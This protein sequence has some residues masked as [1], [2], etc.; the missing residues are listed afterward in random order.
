MS[1]KFT[2]IFLERLPAIAVGDPEDLVGSVLLQARQQWLLLTSP[3]LFHKH[4]I[5]FIGRLLACQ[6]GD[7][8]ALGVDPVGTTVDLDLL[9]ARNNLF[10]RAPFFRFIN[11]TK[12]LVSDM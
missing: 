7:V 5:S 6:I 3:L 4:S 12:D 1:I 2:H 8:L 10:S 9:L 11:P